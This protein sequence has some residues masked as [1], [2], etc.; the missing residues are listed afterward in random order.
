MDKAWYVCYVLERIVSHLF[1]EFYSFELCTVV[2]ITLTLLQLLL[3]AKIDRWMKTYCLHCTFFHPS[4]SIETEMYK[5]IWMMV[6]Q[7][8]Y[9]A[10]N[11]CCFR[12][13]DW[14]EGVKCTGLKRSTIRTWFKCAFSFVFIIHSWNFWFVTSKHCDW[15][16]I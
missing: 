8:S 10:I 16:K 15:F 1:V 6:I 11:W 12:C 5:I 7:N 9:P 14:N 2:E 3:S 13:D 4:K